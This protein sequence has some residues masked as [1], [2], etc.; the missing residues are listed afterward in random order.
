MRSACAPIAV[1]LLGLH[2]QGHP[3]HQCDLIAVLSFPCP[4]NPSLDSDAE[5]RVKL[6]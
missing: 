2:W 6:P 1:Y 3:L 4:L 5:D